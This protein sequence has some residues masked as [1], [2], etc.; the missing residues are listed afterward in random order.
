MPPITHM[1]RKGDVYTLFRKTS[2][3]GTPRYV[4]A[5]ASTGGQPVAELPAG[6]RISEGPNGRVMLVRD[7]AGLIRAEEVTAVEAAVQSHP[8]GR[9]YAVVCKQDR[10]VIHENLGPRASELFDLMTGVTGSRADLAEKAREIERRAAR[11]VPVLQFILSDRD[12][13]TFRVERWCFLGSID[14]WLPLWRTGTAAEL[15]A[16][17]VPAL[18]TD[19]YY[20]LE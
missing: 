8:D 15:A 11:F 4:F 17:I 12:A 19:A 6:Y 1:N 14:D 13:R 18:G 5:R 20:D 9:N 2:A 3:T 10:I 16:A 7:R